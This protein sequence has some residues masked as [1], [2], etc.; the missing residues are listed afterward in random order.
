MNGAE[1]VK[2]GTQRQWATYGVG[3]DEDVCVGS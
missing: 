3:D 2:N 1:I